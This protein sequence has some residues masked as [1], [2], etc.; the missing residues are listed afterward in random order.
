MLLRKSSEKIHLQYCAYLLKNLHAGGRTPF[1]SVPFK[2]QRTKAHP[3]LQWEQEQKWRWEDTGCVK[4]LQM[5][6]KGGFRLNL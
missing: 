3:G 6:G 5:R 1:K 2:G 4:A